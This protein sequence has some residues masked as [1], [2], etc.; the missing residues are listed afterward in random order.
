MRREPSI[1]QPACV[2]PRRRSHRGRYGPL[3]V[4]A[5]SD[6][7]RDGVAG[8]PRHPGPLEDAT[9]D[10][11]RRN[12]GRRPDRFRQRILCGPTPIETLGD[13]YLGDGDSRRPFGDRQGLTSHTHA[14]V[15]VPVSGLL[16]ARRPPTVLRGVWAIIV[17]P[18]DRV[19]RRGARPHVG[20][21]GLEGVAPA[22]TDRDA[23]AT[24]AGVGL[25]VGVSTPLDRSLPGSI[26][27][28][29]EPSMLRRGDAGP[30]SLET[31]ARHE[32]PRQWGLGEV[33][34]FGSAVALHRPGGAVLRVALNGSHNQ[35]AEPHTYPRL[36]LAI[37]SHRSLYYRKRSRLD[38]Y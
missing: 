36:R 11:I 28:R 32:L 23:S 19:L 5:Q 24:V 12:V 18:I 7:F 13:D 33:V 37:T 1:R 21:E 16:M 14:T 31:T 35:P 4:P 6:A 34:F 8:N 9:S 30:L 2:S 38:R 3:V 26:F 29:A 27:R 22:V 20:I 10:S 25:V 15:I 17:D